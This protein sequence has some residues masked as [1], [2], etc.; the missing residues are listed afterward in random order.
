MWYATYRVIYTRRIQYQ[1]V[2]DVPAGT[3]SALHH[4]NARDRIPSHARP[5]QRKGALPRDMVRPTINITN[6]NNFKQ[7]RM[8]H[9]TACRYEAS[10]SLPSIVVG[11]IGVISGC[12]NR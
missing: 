11:V 6:M 9:G 7:A 3:G 1:V 4:R 8:I 2:R 10:L 5:N 12:Y